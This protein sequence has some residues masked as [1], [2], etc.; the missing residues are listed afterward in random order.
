MANNTQKLG[1]GEVRQAIRSGRLSRDFRPFVTEEFVMVMQSPFESGLITSDRSYIMEDVRFVL[2]TRGKVTVSVNLIEHE[3][4]AGDLLVI[5]YGAVIQPTTVSED[6]MLIGMMI[7]PA[8]LRIVMADNTP[9]SL[10]SPSGVTFI[11]HSEEEGVLARH[12]LENIWTLTQAYG[13]QASVMHPALRMYIEY[14]HM[15][16]KRNLG[17]EE[18]KT[19]H[20]ENQFN[21]FV[22]LINKYCHEQ[23][24]IDFYADRMCITNHYLGTL[25]KQ[26]SGLTAKEWIDK[27]LITK[28][29]MLLKST[30]YQAAQIA[31]QLG[32]PNASFFSK[33]F[34]RLT[35]MTP[36]GYRES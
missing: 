18:K 3:A 4:K 33:F 24:N 1:F 25:I 31:S 21:R 10:H 16:K 7:S 6:F 32:F 30:D 12:M 35:G 20:G 14:L 11:P 13:F 5:N 26:Q 19:G 2:I 8:L 22:E 15:L 27:A 9:Q 23:H 36:Q 17:M 28:S 29:K 34:K